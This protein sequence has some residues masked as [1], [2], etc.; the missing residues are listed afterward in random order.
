[1]AATL[2]Y[3]PINLT[4]PLKSK[5]MIS[6]STQKANIQLTN[7]SLIGET[8]TGIQSQQNTSKTL[9][10][11]VYAAIFTKPLSFFKENQ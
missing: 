6:S 7:N 3:S 5:N 11:M 2:K 4:A 1:M 8:Q 10:K 9:R